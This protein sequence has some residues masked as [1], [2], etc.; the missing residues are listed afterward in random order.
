MTEPL[1]RVPDLNSWRDR[2]TRVQAAAAQAYARLLCH[3]EDGR[4]GQAEKIVRFVASTYD[5]DAF[6]FDLFALRGVDVAISD[7]M[8]I[9]VDA[10]RW[11]QADLFKLV[12]GGESRVQAL[13]AAW[14]L[15]CP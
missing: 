7:D 3:A 14:G 6:P 15:R 5:G 10:L 2:A 13:L 12:P 11:G 8:L 9:C 1:P 4:S